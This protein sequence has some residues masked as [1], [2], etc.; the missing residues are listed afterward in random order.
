[1]KYF[2]MRWCAYASI[3]ALALMCGCGKAPAPAA[4]Q[5]AVDII[6]VKTEEVKLQDIQETFEY[7]A[8]IKAQ[9]E[10]AVL[11][12]VS[13]K[14]I[15][16]TKDEGMPVSKGEPIMFIDR[17]EVGLV[18]E[19][20]PVESPIDGVVGKVYVDIGA[21][22][23]PQTIVAL[24]VK[25]E[26]AKIYVDIPEKYL[27]RVTVG[28]KA[29][30]SVDAYA[31]EV[32]IGAVTIVS[33]MVD[34][35]TRAASVEIVVDNSDYRLKSGMFAKVR[36]IVQEHKDSVA[37]LKEA[38]MGKAPQHYVYIVQDSKAV[39]RNITLGIRQGA[40]FQVT[41]GLQA[42][43]RVVVM[44]QQRLYEGAPVFLEDNGT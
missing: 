7:V 9:E 3:G 18:F 5:K 37:V 12:K 22:V 39:L 23:T 29:E 27:H 30:V 6:P 38:I 24:V 20:A 31:Q 8:N 43:D 26:K 1:M 11:P 25:M 10:V 19:K 40:Y 35:V 2:S 21:P 15:Q 13:G 36:L 42:N 16:K 32:F 34:T 17:D 33:P 4:K 14:V 41:Q 28:M 44:G